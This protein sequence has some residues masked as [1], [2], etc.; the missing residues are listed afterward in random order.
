MDR[1]CL[2][3]RGLGEL[4]AYGVTRTYREQQESPEL[5]EKEKGKQRHTEKGK[6]KNRA[7]PQEST[8][9]AYTRPSVQYPELERN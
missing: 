7:K 2:G 6:A 1:A 5:W 8:C 4:L 9:V 3:A